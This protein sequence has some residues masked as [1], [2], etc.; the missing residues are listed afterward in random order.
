[1]E[2]SDDKPRQWLTITITLAADTEQ[3]LDEALDNFTDDAFLWTQQPID[4]F[5]RSQREAHAR[6][7]YGTPDWVVCP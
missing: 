5:A 6:F 3:E 2:E 1:M 4:A 7:T